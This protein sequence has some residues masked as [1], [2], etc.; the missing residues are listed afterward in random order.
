MIRISELTYNFIFV[1][2]RRWAASGVLSL[3][4]VILALP[5]YLSVEVMLIK[6]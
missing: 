2:D 5:N 1:A 3:E 6:T 4:P